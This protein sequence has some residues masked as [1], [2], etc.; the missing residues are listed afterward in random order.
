LLQKDKIKF[1]VFGI[2]AIVLISALLIVGKE[3]VVMKYV[4]GACLAAWLI[5]MFMLNKKFK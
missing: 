3:S 2:L 1:I 4:S 5:T